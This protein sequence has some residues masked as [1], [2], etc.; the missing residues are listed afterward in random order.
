MK[1]RLHD[2][3]PNKHSPL[4]TIQINDGEGPRSTFTKLNKLKVREEELEREEVHRR[5]NKG[6]MAIVED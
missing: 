3:S 2:N 4:K 5:L 6:T 1:E